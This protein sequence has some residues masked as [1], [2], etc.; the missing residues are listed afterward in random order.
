MSPPASEEGASQAAPLRR[1]L[2]HPLAG[3][4]LTT[5]VRLLARHGGCSPRYIAQVALMLAGA[6]VRE[7]FCLIETLRVARRVRSVRFEPPPVIIVGHWRSGTTFLHNLMSRDARFCFPTI[8]DA[9]RPHEFYPGPLEFVSRGMIMSSLPAV[10]PMD[11]VPLRPDLPQE[12]ELALA[13]LGAPSFFNCFYFPRRLADVFRR[14]VL[15]EG[16]DA[17]SLRRWRHDLVYYLAKIA[18]LHPG[19]R[20]LLK[21]PAHSARLPEITALFPSAKFIHIHRDPLDVFVSMRRLFRG[22]LP[23]V[24]LQDYETERIDE[25]IMCF[26]PMIVDRMCAALDDLDPGAYV[27]V[28]YADLVRQ[29][30]ETVERIYRDLDLGDF[31]L[32]RPA[33]ARFA[34]EN[35]ASPRRARALDAALAERIRERWQRQIVRLGYGT[36]DGRQASSEA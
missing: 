10:R 19:K 8:A 18:A 11:E 34:A 1:P 17:R 5:L 9:V 16:I 28:S 6:V 23:M 33:I 27:E 20:L 21:N 24:A 26:Y 31:A 7:P 35:T 32:A 13:S 29:P 12:D 36:P 14:E 3:A 2:L 25:H 15:F 30:V 4:R 22:M